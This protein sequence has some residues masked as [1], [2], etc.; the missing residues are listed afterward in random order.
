[1]RTDSLDRFGTK[2]EKRFSLIEIKEI[3]KDAK[4]ENIINSNDTPF[5]CVLGHKKSIK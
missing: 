1:M 5:W 4:F 3:L 2:L